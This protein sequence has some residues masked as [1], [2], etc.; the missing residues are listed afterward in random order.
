M[1]FP[2]TIWELL[3]LV[4]KGRVTLDREPLQWIEAALEAVPMNEA[5]LTI[6]VAIQSRLVDLPH[7]DPADRFL[8]ATAKVYGLT[9]VTADDNILSAKTFSLFPNR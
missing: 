9:F 5:P 3:I 7:Q 1:D 8:A 4:E 6:D 2:V